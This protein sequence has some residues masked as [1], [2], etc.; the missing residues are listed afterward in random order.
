MADPFAEPTYPL[1][2]ERSGIKYYLVQD[3]AQFVQGRESADGAGL[4]ARFH[5]K[6][7][8]A[9]NWV[10]DMRG[11]AEVSGTHLARYAPERVGW[12]RNPTAADADLAP[13]PYYCTDLQLLRVWGNGFAADHP[14]YMPGY[15]LSPQ[16][17]GLWVN[18]PR[19]LWT[20]WQVQYS[21][22]AYAPYADA[23]STFLG[24][25]GGAKSEW[26]R[27]C[28]VRQRPAAENE[29]VPLGHVVYKVDGADR[30]IGEGFFRRG[31]ITRLE[32]RWV[33][34]P[35]PVPE[36][37]IIDCSGKV[38]DAEFVFYLPGHTAA[39]PQKLTL[40]A[41]KMLFDTY[42][43]EPVI[44]PWGF[45]YYNIGYHFIVRQDSRTW[46]KYLD[47]DGTTLR[48]LKRRYGAH[49]HTYADVFQTVDMAKLFRFT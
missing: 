49:P 30:E 34:V 43:L 6:F 47:P 38:N 37:N 21:A 32:V 22:L 20:E 39:V 44:G 33:G 14:D 24:F 27:Y 1:Q 36:A 31:C 41:G 13:L 40:A 3:S 18:W 15:S 5:V 45:V 23:D 25:N 29:R 8:D 4:T 28:V 11:V 10:R 17:N 7:D 42:D 48:D 35:T 26:N 46:N 19:P 12:P 2:T 9:F 16:P